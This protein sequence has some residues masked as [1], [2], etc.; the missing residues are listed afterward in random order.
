MMH[1][2]S[3]PRLQWPVRIALALVISMLVSSAVA[4]QPSSA[5]KV[6]ILTLGLPRL[7]QNALIYVAD[8]R[9]F[10]AANGL[11]V[12]IKDYDTGVA[13][14]NSLLEGE[15]ELAGAAEFPVVRALLQKSPIRVIASY[16]KFENDYLVGRKDRG[17]EVVSDLRGKRIGVTLQTINEFYLA[18]FLELNGIDLQEVAPVD[19]KPAQFVNAIASGE[20]DALIAWQPYIHQILEG[21]ANIVVWP[22]QNN[23]AVYGLL[24]CKDEWLALH[25]NTVER[26]LQALESAEGY[27]I[28]NPN[29]ALTIV[30]ERL[31]YDSAYIA[32]VWPQHRFSL[33]LDF[34]LVI[35][36]TDE[37]RWSIDN[38][39]VDEKQVPNFVDF[40][41]TDALK[42]V[43]PEAVDILR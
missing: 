27:I 14:I 11:E 41:Y 21:Q 22:A 33:S 34:S 26:F 2:S 5:D 40:I 9:G 23:Q 38:N 1:P 36:M 25:G 43:R 17:I 42:A 16:D 15:V 6:E 32:S 8:E 12:L 35:A 24:V 10:F 37:A 4:C 39:L 31:G 13:A 20:V 18:R 28:S 30:Q 29:E 7:E 3:S 19:L